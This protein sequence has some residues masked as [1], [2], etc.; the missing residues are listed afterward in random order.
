MRDRNIF[1]VM[2]GGT[3]TTKRDKSEGESWLNPF[4]GWLI[5]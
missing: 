3:R 4:Q 1:A 5:D 2:E